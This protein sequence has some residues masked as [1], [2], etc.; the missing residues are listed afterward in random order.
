VQ[1][2]AAAPWLG[3]LGRLNLNHNSAAADGVHALAMG[4]GAGALFALHLR[5]NEFDTEAVKVLAESP[6]VSGLHTL[7]LSE[8][9]LDEEALQVLASSHLAPL[10]D[11]CL[12]H[13]T[14][15]GQSIHNLRAAPWL[16]RLVRL[17]LSNNSLGAAGLK[18]LLA[19]GGLARVNE[20]A[21][22]ACALG[23][24]G[25]AALAE[26]ELPELHWLNLARNELGPNGVESLAGSGLT[27]TLEELNLDANVLSDRAAE[28]LAAATWPALMRLSLN[29]NHLTDK[30][31]FAL[32][33]AKMLPRLGVICCQG[34]RLQWDTFR[35][36]GPRFRQWPSW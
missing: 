6:G 1:A 7:D 13:C 8:N 20:L 15:D 11:L 22:Q 35:K 23:P 27:A 30:G 10:R 4:V 9:A 32:G 33:E 29:S 34:N 25:A 16:P 17:S 18:A 24:A 5:D 31:A 3:R 21:L 28:L 19:G 2:L 12:D 36:L 26:A 14:L